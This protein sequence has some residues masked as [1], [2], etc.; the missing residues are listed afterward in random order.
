MKR[1]NA[2]ERAEEIRKIV[3]RGDLRKYYRVPRP[4]RWYGGISTGDCCGCNL[5]CVFCWSNAPRDAP[6]KMGKFY[7]P[8]QV[9]HEIISCAKKHKYKLLRISG[10]EPTI[11]KDHI[12]KLLE[13]VDKTE[14]LFILETNS[15]LIDEEFTYALSSFKN[16]HVRV[17][18][19]GTN[20]KEFAVLTG[21]IPELRHSIK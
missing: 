21:A 19:K 12:L 8:E 16:V 20:G 10:N 7:T 18:L 2:L 11:S 13:M 4:G 3:V 17:S 1:Y 5:R 15:T 6:E 9:F 14:Y